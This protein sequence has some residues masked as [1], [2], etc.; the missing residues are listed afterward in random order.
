MKFV[1]DIRDQERVTC[2]LGT[3]NWIFILDITIYKSDNCATQA[4]SFKKRMF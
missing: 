2:P 1:E 3:N 4:L